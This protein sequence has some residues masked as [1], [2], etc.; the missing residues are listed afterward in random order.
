MALSVQ[1][2]SDRIEIEDLL[3]RYT[4]SIDAKD[5][6]RLDT[7]FT[8]DATLDYTTSGGPVGPY[9]DVK[10]W[11][12]RALA[13]FPMTHH[14]IGKSSIDLDGDTAHCRTIFYN[15]MGMSIDET[16]RFIPGGAAGAGQHVFIVGGFYNDTCA[17][18]ADGWRIVHK[19]EEQSYLY[20]TFAEGFDIPS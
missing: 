11:L 19:F 6:D 20:G 8:V 2:I 13:H 14:M 17:R 18:L 12:Q 10:A 15:P 5:W 7:V 1:Q 16:G 3:Q 9:P 4:S